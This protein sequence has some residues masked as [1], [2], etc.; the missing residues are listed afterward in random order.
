MW[1][2]TPC[3]VYL[4]ALP[5]A[6]ATHHSP[7]L[8]ALVQASAFRRV[9]VTL[10]TLN[11]IERVASFSGPWRK[12]RRRSGGTRR[13]GFRP[14]QRAQQQPRGYRKA[15]LPWP[16]QRA[17]QSGACREPWLPLTAAKSWAACASS[18]HDCHDHGHG[19]FKEASVLGNILKAT[20]L[21]WA[22]A[23]I[24]CKEHNH[25][26][27]AGE[28][29]SW[30]TM[31]STAM[32]ILQL[33]MLAATTS[34]GAILSGKLCTLQIHCHDHDHDHGEIEELAETDCDAELQHHHNHWSIAAM[35]LMTRTAR[36][37]LNQFKKYLYSVK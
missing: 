20:P 15:C 3:P 28:H 10:E 30:A 36:L 2:V 14:L 17:R 25:S 34:I 9:M 29:A 19:H 7:P 1:Q 37:Q 18:R 22:W 26:D 13:H 6:S 8:R 4:V 21:P 33:S 11:R 27:S 5:S 24:Y 31:E 23:Y 16:P 32:H 35:N 12:D